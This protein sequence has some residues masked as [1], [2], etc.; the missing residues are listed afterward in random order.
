MPLDWGF[1]FIDNLNRQ[2]QPLPESLSMLNYSTNEF[3]RVLEQADRTVSKPLP[4]GR[5]G[6]TPTSGASF[7]YQT[8]SGYSTRVLFYL[9]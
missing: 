5:V 8:L 2:R 9:Y 1:G 4:S 3:A 7:N 6:S